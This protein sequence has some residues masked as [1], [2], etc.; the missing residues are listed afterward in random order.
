M[1]GTYR[2]TISISDLCYVVSFRNMLFFIL[3]ELQISNA[4]LMLKFETEKISDLLLIL[5]F[6]TKIHV[7]L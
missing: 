2:P 5:L 3:D 4:L 6:A 1:K 7:L